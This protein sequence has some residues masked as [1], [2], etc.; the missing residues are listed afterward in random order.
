MPCN[1]LLHHGSDAVTREEVVS[2][3]TPGSTRT[4]QPIPHR[5]LLD[6]VEDTLPRYGCRKYCTNGGNPNTKNFD[7]ARSGAG[8][9]PAP[10]S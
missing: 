4:W 2:A 3:P 6:Q 7:R 9:T 1:L 10:K 8:S 5:T